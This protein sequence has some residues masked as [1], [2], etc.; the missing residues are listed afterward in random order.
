MMAL[1]P[2]LPASSTSSSG[3]LAPSRKLYAECACSSAYGTDERIVPP[4]SGGW[5]A[6]RLRDH[7]ASS[8]GP[9]TDGVPERR[10]LPDSTRSIS[11][12][13]GGPLLQPTRPVY[14]IYV[15]FVTESGQAANPFVGQRKKTPP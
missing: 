8:A 9:H 15:R 13:P 11:A 6:T 14:R 3:A 7:G 12:Q 1:R 10:G 2:I 4:S 5:Y